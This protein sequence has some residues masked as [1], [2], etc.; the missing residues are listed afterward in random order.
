M[1]LREVNSGGSSRQVFGAVLRFYREK[2]GLSRPELA[3]RVHKSVSLIQAIELGDRVATP[4]VTADLEAVA[5]LNTDGILMMLRRK[6]GDSMN[7]G[8]SLTYHAVPVWF[9]GWVSNERVAVRLRTFEP[10]LVPGLLQTEAYAHAVLTDRIVGNSGDA[11][12]LVAA[13]LARQAV[14][15][16]D[17]N[18]A[19]Y[20]AVIDEWA[21]RRPVGGATVMSEQVAHLIK[22][23]QWPNVVIQVIPASTGVHDGLAGG[24]FSVAEFEDGPPLAYQETALQGQVFDDPKAVAALAALWDKTRTDALPRTASLALLEEMATAWSQTA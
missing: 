21:L 4:N 11:E 20:V 12:D 23:A 1:V 16:R 13:R 3:G 24:G 19:K 22:V 6:F 2:A 15:T 9:A 10:L 8:D 7:Y 18:P 17:E 5:D 14:L